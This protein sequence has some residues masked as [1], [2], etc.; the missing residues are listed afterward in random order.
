MAKGCNYTY[1]RTK[2]LSWMRKNE[3]LDK[4]NNI[5][6]YKSFINLRAK[7][8]KA[9][10]IT[11]GFEENPFLIEDVGNRDKAFVNNAL[12]QK[13]DAIE[14]AF[15]GAN[16]KY[17]GVI[18]DMENDFGVKVKEWMSMKKSEREYIINCHKK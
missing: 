3:A 9:I 10:A 18:Q 7:L 5:K 6:D 13:I 1:A 12:F 14:G 17:R 2:A 8:K 11:Y 16:A 15:Y 4:Y